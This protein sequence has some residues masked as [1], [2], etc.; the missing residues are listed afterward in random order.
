MADG[1]LRSKM[2]ITNV[3]YKP[4]L[5]TY[6]YTFFVIIM[7]LVS[8]IKLIISNNNEVHFITSKKTEKI[9]KNSKQII[10]EKLINKI[11]KYFF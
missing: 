11:V 8:I 7:L 6:K 2:L 5:N 1:E 4:R 3:I 9:N 10:A